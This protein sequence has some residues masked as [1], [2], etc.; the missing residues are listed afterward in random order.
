MGK[1]ETSLKF[2]LFWC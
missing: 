2:A 1:L